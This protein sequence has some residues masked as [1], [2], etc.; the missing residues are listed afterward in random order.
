MTMIP[1]DLA[2][3]P[4]RLHALQRADSSTSRDPEYVTGYL[5]VPL[6]ASADWLDQQ[7]SLMREALPIGW[8]AHW[9][10]TDPGDTRIV[11]RAELE[12]IGGRYRCDE[13]CSVA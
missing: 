8:S 2:S 1:A 6:D 3:L 12:T 11:V 13:G 9:L 7:M 5:T 4:Y 10:D